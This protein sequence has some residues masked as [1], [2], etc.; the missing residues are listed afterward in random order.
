MLISPGLFYMTLGMFKYPVLLWPVMSRWF[1]LAVLL[2][3]SFVA[4]QE[5]PYPF[6]VLF[7]SFRD[8]GN[9]ALITDVPASLQFTNLDLGTRT[10]MTRLIDNDG[11]SRYELKAGN[12]ELEAVLDDQRT[13]EADYFVRTVFL[14]EPENFVTN[15]SVFT[16]PVGSLEGTVIDRANNRISGAALEFSCKSDQHSAYPIETNQFGAFSADLVPEG[17]CRVSAA[18]EGKVGTEEVKVI[19]GELVD[20]TVNLDRS[21]ISSRSNY[22]FIGSGVALLLIAIVGVFIWKRKPKPKTHAEPSPQPIVEEKKEEKK[23]ELNPRARDIMA[24]LSENE[25]AI[26]KFLLGNNFE[27]TQAKMRNAL[28]IP[29]TT[30]AR[31]FLSLEEK[32]VLTVEKIGKMKKVVLTDWFLG[33]D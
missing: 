29:K 5:E 3:I 11:L 20:V 13:P 12:W 31:A 21:I 17:K 6:A 19:R 9:N 18:Y 26:V 23:E 32:K 1:P 2:A 10:R 30:L 4:A 27:S 15:L 8:I 28:G 16:T 33:K 22:W 25:V 7:L 14:I 24:T